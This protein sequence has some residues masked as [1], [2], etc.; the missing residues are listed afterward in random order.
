MDLPI[1]RSYGTLVVTVDLG[2]P[3]FRS[4]G[5]GNDDYDINFPA[6]YY[7]W[8]NDLKFKIKI[9]ESR[10]RMAFTLPA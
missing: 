6:I 2:L 10:C 5:T 9:G 8:G 3:I 7:K 4:Y 1:F